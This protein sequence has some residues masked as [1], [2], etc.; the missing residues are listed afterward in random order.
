MRSKHAISFVDSKL[1]QTVVFNPL[2]YYYMPCHII[3]GRVITAPNR[4]LL[5][6]YWRPP[7]HQRYSMHRI[8]D[9][10]FLVQHICTR[11]H[12]HVY[13]YMD[14]CTCPYAH[15]H[16]VIPIDMVMSINIH[17]HIY[18]HIYTYAHAYTYTYTNTY[19]DTYTDYAKEWIILR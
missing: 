16:T 5:L 8:S 13:V 11:A 1:F 12:V 2:L 6:P 15:M 19:K 7:S 10:G 9:N 18:I 3:F 17:M 14:T 4:N